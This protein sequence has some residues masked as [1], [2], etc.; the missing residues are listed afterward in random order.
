ALSRTMW[1][2]CRGEESEAASVAA[3]EVLEKL[4]ATSELASAYANLAFTHM[5]T[6]PAEAVGLARQAQELAK[7]FG[8]S[9]VLSD[10]LNTEGCARIVLGENG[11]EQLHRALDVALAAQLEEQ[12]GRAYANLQS[13]LAGQYRF[14]DAEKY[15]IDGLAYADEHDIGT[16]GTCLRGG[17][18]CC[19]ES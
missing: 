12:A 5:N 11:L 10:A 17:H 15:Y 16:Y 6:D 2:L 14:A 4:P 3:V 8:A 13:V 19:L 9:T 18:A 1:R 7:K